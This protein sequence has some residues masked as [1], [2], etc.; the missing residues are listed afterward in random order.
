MGE[1]TIFAVEIFDPGHETQHAALAHVQ[2]ALQLCANSA[3]SAGGGVT[4]G[5]VMGDRAAVMG[6]WKFTWQER[7]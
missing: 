7:K 5:V 6:R 1:R 2:R 4:E 3:R